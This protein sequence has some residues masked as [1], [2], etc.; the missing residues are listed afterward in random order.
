M[1]TVI[2]LRRCARELGCQC[3]GRQFLQDTLTDQGFWLDVC[4][5]C[6]EE[7]NLQALRAQRERLI[8]LIRS[9]L[10]SL[11]TTD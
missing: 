2:F 10:F 3:C 9:N 6:Q 11:C 1:V 7:A 5:R 8:H 4:V